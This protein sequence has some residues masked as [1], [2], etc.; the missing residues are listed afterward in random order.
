LSFGSLDKG[1]QPQEE[2][3]RG[4]LARII[5][6]TDRLDHWRGL[7]RRRDLSGVGQSGLPAAMNRWLYRAHERQVRCLVDELDLRPVDVYEIGVGTG[8]WVAFWR[9]FGADVRGGD[10]VPEA[11]KR[12]GSGF[13]RLDITSDRPIGTH[14]LV[15]VAN[16][17][18]HVL[19]DERFAAAMVN[20]AAA[21][22]TGGYLMM[23]EPLQVAR[24]RPRAGDRD[25]RARPSEAYLEPLLDAGLELIQL[26]P[27]TALTSDPIEGSSRLRYRARLA[28]WRALKGPARFW[29]ALGGPMGF[30]AYLLDPV[31]LK[32][33]GGASSKLVVMHRPNA[34]DDA[35]SGARPVSA[36]AVSPIAAE[37]KREPPG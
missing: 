16:V 37:M 3:L 31:V 30:L 17:L 22:A 12:L 23:V 35:G 9:S 5:M 26:R 24:Y 18:L 4:H 8:Y 7:H 10:F 33:A 32:L 19:D 34:P 25:S 2:H 1:R 6:V 14:Q 21:V 29:P 27:A 36:S 15:W 28:I 20:V 13:E 11:V